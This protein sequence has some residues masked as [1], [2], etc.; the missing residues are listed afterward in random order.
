VSV[1]KYVA[2]RFG[3]TLFYDSIERHE[4][5]GISML[6]H[7]GLVAVGG[8]IGATLRYLLGVWFSTDSFPYSTLSVNLIGSFLL[9]VLTVAASHNF[10]S[11]NVALLLG[12]G[13]LGAF[14][15]MSTFSVETI[16]MFDQGH[17][18]SAFLYVGLT[19]LFCPLLA[20]LGWVFG[21]SYWP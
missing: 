3:P 4:G 1:L 9:G 12:T 16:Q 8:A 14:T 5:G 15:T 20:L 17:T 10:V 11:T 6:Q 19:M 18:V 21:E 13:I 7:V 2:E